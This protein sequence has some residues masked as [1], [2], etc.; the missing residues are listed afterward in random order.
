[1]P[2]LT[3]KNNIL[4]T[5][6]EHP[7]QIRRLWIEQGSERIFEDCIRE[8]KS[9]GIQFRVLSK[10]DFEK[11]FGHLKTRICL[12]RDDFSYMDPDLL[13]HE[14][15]G[16]KNPFLCAFDGVKDPQN[17]GNILRS[18][19]CFGVEALIIPKDRACAVT[20]TTIQIARG[21]IE[22]ATVSRVTNLARYLDELKQTGVFCYGLDEKGGQPLWQI[23]LNGPV[24]LV[25]G[26]EDGMRRL[27]RDKCDGIARIPSNPSF[28][29]LNVA[30][31]FAIAAYEVRKQRMIPA[32]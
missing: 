18:A 20:E 25:L 11:Q 1:M 13:L 16:R 14:I 30:T 21:G 8:A 29:S 10:R 4:E 5:I 7:G 27:T 15:K 22:H 31:C 2:F 32:V 28:S 23:D 19:A 24:C 3:N 17:L 12:E 9:C 6:K 26:G